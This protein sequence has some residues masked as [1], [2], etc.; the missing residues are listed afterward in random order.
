[1]YSFDIAYTALIGSECIRCGPGSYNSKKSLEDGY[2]EYL[3]NETSVLDAN[4]VLSLAE[5]AYFHGKWALETVN[6]MSE[7]ASSRTFGRT[8]K[9]KVFIIEKMEHEIDGANKSLSLAVDGFL[10][11]AKNSKNESYAEYLKRRKLITSNTLS[12][13]NSTEI[14]RDTND[15]KFAYGIFNKSA[16]SANLNPILAITQDL[17]KVNVHQYTSSTGLEFD[18]LETKFGETGIL[19]FT[20]LNDNYFET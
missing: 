18:G 8:E 6:L 9:H 19:G 5:N 14:I 12:I 11:L 3:S 1:M 10:G 7:D 17:S 4:E 16:P 13:E 15:Y 2:L 20:I